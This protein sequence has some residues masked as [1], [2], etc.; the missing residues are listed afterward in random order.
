MT[1]GAIRLVVP[2][3]GGRM[4]SAP[5][6]SQVFEVWPVD[7]GSYG[8]GDL[9]PHLR[10]LMPS[11]ACLVRSGHELMQAEDRFGDQE[12][13]PPLLQCIA[14]RCDQLRLDERGDSFCT[15]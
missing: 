9:R 11:E 5:S 7:Q 12:G 3:G 4:L 14:R 13:R 1:V 6:P 2:P 15:I 10:P 8:V